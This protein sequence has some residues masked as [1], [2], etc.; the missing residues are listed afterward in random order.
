MSNLNTFKQNRRS[1]R[2]FFFAFFLIFLLLL[3]F[4]ELLS[5]TLC[6][7]GPVWIG[8]SLSFSFPVL[9]G[10]KWA[11]FSSLNIL[12]IVILLSKNSLLP[13]RLQYTF[14]VN[15]SPSL[16][17]AMVIHVQCRY[18][19]ISHSVMSES[20]QPHES[21]HARP[22]CL[23]PSPRVHSNSTS[24]ELVMPSS[25]L[26]DFGTPQNKSLSQFPLFPHLFPMKWWDQMPWS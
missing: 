13:Q 2:F 12:L 9:C 6:I 15:L 19:Q 16:N 7:P 20:L 8:Y 1:L 23:S 14:L 18:L 10:F 11:F 26:S 17:N 24:I 21:Q 3:F 25:H 4:W 22:P 5:Q